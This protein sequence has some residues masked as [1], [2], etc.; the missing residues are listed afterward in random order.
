[1]TTSAPAI[2]AIYVRDVLS[3]IPRHSP[4]RQRIEDDLR[5]RMRAHL[6]AGDT[7]AAAIAA[8]GDPKA[9]AQSYLGEPTLHYAPLGLR[10]LAACVDFMVLSA[11]WITPMALLVWLINREATG[12]L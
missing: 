2:V 1:M 9:V 6:E 3:H 7:P 11:G 5:A 4:D 10:L 12:W 8:I